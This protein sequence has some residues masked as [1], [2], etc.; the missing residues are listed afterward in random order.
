[1][2]DPAKLLPSIT[3]A[4]KSGHPPSFA[5]PA[6][7]LPSGRLISQT[8]NILNYLAPKLGL[9]GSK[10]GEEGEEERA[11]INQ[12]VL[13]ALDLCNEVRVLLICGQNQTLTTINQTHDVHHPIAVEKYYNEQKN[14]AAARAKSYRANR[15]PKFLKHFEKVLATNPETKDIGETYLIGSTTTTADLTLFHVSTRR[16]SAVGVYVNRYSRC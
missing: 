7:K 2:K 13:T 4:S 15:L 3:D 8:P 9:A 5:P 16:W 10:E 14:A 1:M 6:L 12:L 11:S